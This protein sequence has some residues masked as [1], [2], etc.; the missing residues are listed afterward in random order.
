MEPGGDSL[1]EGASVAGEKGGLPTPTKEKGRSG[2]FHSSPI[3]VQ[4]VSLTSIT[5]PRSGRA[6][7]PAS[8][9]SPPVVEVDS[10][11]ASTRADGS[12]TLSSSP[13][14]VDEKNANIISA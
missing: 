3:K 6:H 11:A 9:Y 7:S 8:S 5:N 10:P 1:N 14:T 13:S 2:P 4:P 12:S